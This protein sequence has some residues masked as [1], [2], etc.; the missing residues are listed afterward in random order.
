MMRFYMILMAGPLVLGAALAQ[1]TAQQDMVVEFGQKSVACSSDSGATI[2]E[3]NLI[4]APEGQYIV[5]VKLE[6][7]EPVKSAGT[8]AGCFE[9]SR[10]QQSVTLRFN[11]SPVAS[12]LDKSVLAQARAVCGANVER[13]SAWCRAVVT[14]APIPQR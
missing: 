6:P 11:G 13:I 7:V 4:T 12:K 8:N 5:A 10:E 2:N 9:M 14:I 3:E 1:S